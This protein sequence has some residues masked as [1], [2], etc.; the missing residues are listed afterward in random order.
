MPLET[1]ES[2]N[3]LDVANYLMEGSDVALVVHPIKETIAFVCWASDRAR[4][5]LMAWGMVEEATGLSAEVLD[6]RELFPMFPDDW[7]VSKVPLKEGLHI[8]QEL[9]LP[10]ARGVVN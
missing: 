1:V 3:S 6:P 2:Q 7:I 8:I 4:D 5:L 10:A 9:A